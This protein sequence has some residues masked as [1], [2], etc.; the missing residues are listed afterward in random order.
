VATLA[1]ILKVEAGC[2]WG[3]LS[4]QGTNTIPADCKLLIIA[5]PEKLRQNYSSNEIAQIQEYLLHNNG[6]LLALLNVDMGLNPLL[7]K[8]WGV[9]LDTNVVEELDPN[10]RIGPGAFEAL[11]HDVPNPIVAPLL[12]QGLTLHMYSP[13]PVFN[14]NTSVNARPDASQIDYLAGTSPNGT[15]GA[16]KG[17]FPLIASIQRGVINDR[18]GTRIVV[19]GDADFLDDQFI[20]Q[21]PGANHFFAGQALKWLLQRPNLVLDGLGPRPIIEYMVSVTRSQMLQARWLFLA[22]M[23]GAVLF[24]GGLVWLRRRS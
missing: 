5:S 4:L 16:R 2:D 21:P 18:D 8:N 7:K 10:Y 13:H 14:T 23:P 24:L 12:A 9:T 22:V 3:V 20:D 11:F 1:A 19:A 17:T 15:D 6:R